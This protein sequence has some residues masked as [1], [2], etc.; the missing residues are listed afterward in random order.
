MCVPSSTSLNCAKRLPMPRAPGGPRAVMA[1][2]ATRCLMSKDQRANQRPWPA[3]GTKDPV[4]VMA[5][6]AGVAGSQKRRT[7]RWKDGR[8]VLGGRESVRRKNSPAL[9]DRSLGCKVTG[10]PRACTRQALRRRGGKRCG[11]AA[12]APRDRVS[13]VHGSDAVTQRDGQAQ[14]QR[15][16]ERVPGPGPYCTAQ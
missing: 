1:W 6:S 12:S 13:S 5:G 9:G 15:R 16:H 4:P 8:R 7:S 3:A 11:E 10:W 14:P 2:K